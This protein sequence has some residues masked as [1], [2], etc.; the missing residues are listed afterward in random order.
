MSK[1]KLIAIVAAAVAV[2]AGSAAYA[3]IPDGNG[4]IHACYW[5]STTGPLRIIDPAQGQKCTSNENALDWSQQ[6]PPGAP[7]VQ[8]DKGDPG[9]QGPAGVSGYEVVP[10][11]FPLPWKMNP[12]QTSTIP[13]LC[14]AGETAIGIAF[15]STVALAVEQSAPGVQNAPLEWDL[16][17]KNIDNQTGTLDVS[18][19][20]VIAS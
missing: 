11:P 1:F 4:V 2:I 16:K 6:G 3:A 18:V 13:T 15:N 9:Q 14:N 10:H 12:G 19:V 7:G 8:G 5:K 17:V 20:C